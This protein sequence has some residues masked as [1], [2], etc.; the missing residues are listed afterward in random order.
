[1][2]AGGGVLGEWLW[3]ISLLPAIHTP[4][5]TGA[6]FQL[7]QEPQAVQAGGSGAEGQEGEAHPRPL[8]SPE[9]RIT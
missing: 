5:D 4:G 7:R 3:P 6:L 1:M 2:G 8:Q 9:S